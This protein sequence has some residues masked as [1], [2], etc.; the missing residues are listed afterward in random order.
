ML[1]SVVPFE[2]FD[3]PPSFGGGG[4]FIERSLAVDV[5]IVLDQDDGLGVGE[6][7]IGQFLQDVSVNVPPI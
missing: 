1:W 2:A 4:G 7:E 6:V 5:K 3:Q